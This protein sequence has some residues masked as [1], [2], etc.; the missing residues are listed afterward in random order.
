MVARMAEALVGRQLGKYRLVELLG[1]GGMAEV[2]RGIQVGLEREVAVKVLPPAFAADREMVK[3]FRRESQATAKLAHPNI[4]TIYD[5]GEQDG[6]HYYVMEYL[7]A[8]SLEG[9]LS[10]EGTLSEARVIKITQEILKALV[11]THEKDILHRDLKPA[12]IKFDQRE[13]AIVTDFGLVKDL[14]ETAITLSGGSPGTPRYM[15]PEQLRGEEIDARSD[16]YQVG[17]M[18]HEMLTGRMPGEGG[19]WREDVPPELREFV[20]RAIAT[21]PEDRFDGAKDML[22]ELRRVELR[23]KARRLGER[24]S[25]VETRA[26][27]LQ[28]DAGSLSAATSVLEGRGPSSD[29]IWA[30][31]IAAILDSPEDLQEALRMMGRALPF[32]VAGMGL[33]IWA[34]RPGAPAVLEHSAAV[35]A[36]RA[37]VVARSSVACASQVEYWRASDPQER[38]RTRLADGPA[39]EHRHEIEALDPD[40]SYRYRLLLGEVAGAHETPES[41]EVLDFRTR[42]ELQIH[43][44]HVE[45]HGDHVIVTWETN[46]RTDTVVRFGREEEDLDEVVSNPDQPDETMH[47]ARIDG[48][49]RGALGYLRIASRDPRGRAAPALSDVVTYVTEEPVTGEGSL[50]QLVKSYID[51]L[52]RMT[53]DERL[54]LHSSVGQFAGPKGDISAEARRELLA[55][56]TDPIREDRFHDRVRQARNWIVALELAGRPVEE[57]KVL[58]SKALKQW[59][60]NAV[61]ASDQLDAVLA[62]LAEIEAG[63]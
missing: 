51:K 9:L 31:S 29:S 11:Y 58:V 15:S 62:R 44:I 61:R 5:S 19:G 16:L 36:T 30:S 53:P 21:A 26:V 59:G 14:G 27:S 8:E 55:E 48:L 23:G 12:N 43:N 6:Y 38:H 18:M 1:S 13:N 45:A 41:L 3:R 20:E 25:A 28:V 46:L 24:S 52:T 49:P 35:E 56:R 63:K 57:V 33:V 34:L 54:K 32:I 2:Y 4:I 17:L 22:Q 47:M 50:I 39:T 10:R 7:R 60:S 37:V 42:P 40:T